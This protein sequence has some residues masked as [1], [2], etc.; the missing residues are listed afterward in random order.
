MLLC[1]INTREYDYMF[2]AGLVAD[3]FFIYSTMDP[4][5]TITFGG[6]GSGSERLKKKHLN[7]PNCLLK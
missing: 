5:P 2:I 4:N 3:I 6:S 7:C 1:F